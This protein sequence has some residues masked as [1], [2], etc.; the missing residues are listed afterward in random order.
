M[1]TVPRGYTSRRVLV[2]VVLIC[3]I[4]LAVLPIGSRGTAIVRASLDGQGLGATPTGRS[5]T[6]ADQSAHN[7][8]TST[9]LMQHGSVEPLS[10]IPPLKAGLVT[11]S[12]AISAV[13][14]PV[15][16]G[17]F[18]YAGCDKLYG[19][20]WDKNLPNSP[21]NIDILDGNSVL[22]TVTA[23]DYRSDLPGNKNHAF[24]YIP[25]ASLKDGRTHTINVRFSGT[26]T[27]LTNSPKSLTCAPPVPTIS[28]YSWSSTPTANQPFNGTITGSGFVFG[29][30]VFFCVN[31]SSTCYEH[32]SAGISVN[33]T[34]SLGVSN[35]NL[36]TG[37]Y[38][39]Y[40]QT[41]GGQSGRS[42]AFNVQSTPTPPT[43][44]NYSWNSTPTANQP[45]GGTITGTGFASGIRVFFCVNGTSTCYEHPSAGIAV[46]G[47]T[48]L[49][50]SNVNLGGGSYQIYVQTSAGQS[51]R[52]TAFTVQAALPTIT[53]YSWNSTPTANQ[54][55]GGTITGTGF[56]SGI[57]V[58]FC[59]NGTGT[60]Y[61][62][63]SA[64]ITVNNSTSLSLSNINLGSGSYQIYV[65]TSAG[66]SAR[67]TAF[68]VQS[69]TPTI[70]G[71]SW[72]ST[73]TPNEPFGGTISGTG[74][75][76][77]ARV[78]FCVNGTATCYE[79]P[80]AGITVNSSTVMS[81]INVNLGSGSYQIYVQTSAGQ[82]ARSTAFTVQSPLPT[83]TTYSWASTPTANQVFGGTITGTGFI[84]GIRVF[85]CVSST[86]TCY[87]HPSVGVI[88]NGSTSLS[89]SNVNLGSGSWQV[90]VQTSAGQSAR[91]TAFTVQAGAQPVITGISPS[92]L[93]SKPTDQNVTVFGNN[94]QQNL[95]VGV[96]FPN[97][98]GATLSGTQIQSVTPNSF[99]MRITLGA[100]GTWSIRVN[101]PDGGQSGTFNFAVQSAVQP[102]GVYS[103][104]PSS[105]FV[106]SSDQDVVVSG[107][108]FQPNLTA[109][110]TFPGGGGTTLS[111][112]QIQN[113]TNSSFILRITLGA[114][115][116]WSL[117]VNN[118]DGGQS[119][120]FNFSVASGG[121]N[122]TIS[123]INPGS[124]VAGGADQNVIISGTNFQPGL[125]VDLGFPN[126]GL[127]TLQGTGQ[128]Q[129]VTANSF[130]MRV[131]LNGAGNWTMRVLNPDGTQSGQFSFSVLS[132]GPPPSGLPTS[133]L[134]PVIGTL[135][136]T[137]SNQGIGDGNWEF[138]Q[139][140][141]GFHTPTGGISSSNDTFAWDANLYTPTSRNADAGKA[142]YAVADG[143]VVSYVGTPP[144][145]GPGA[146]LIAHPNSQNPVWFSGYLHMTNV[147]V[148]MNQQVTT[149]TVIGDVGRIG[150]D[151]DHLHFVV[152]SGQNTRGNLQSFNVTLLERTASTINAPI[153]SSI[154]PSVVDQS[155]TPQLITINGANF[156]SGSI[157]EAQAPNG[158]FFNVTPETAPGVSGDAPTE[159]DVEAKITAVTSNSITA[160]VLFASGGT[161]AFSVINRPT[162]SSPDAPAA[163]NVDSAD[164]SFAVSNSNTVRALQ[165]GR[166]PV[167]LIPGIM[168]SK[169][170]KWEGGSLRNLWPGAANP[171]QRLND[172][173]ELKNNVEKPDDYRDI[174]DRPV[175]AT[176]IIR[177]ISV[178]GVPLKDFYGKLFSYLIGVGYSPYEVT[179]PSQ[180]TIK[181]CDKN[182]VGADL[183][184]FSY[185]W[186]NSN[187]TSARDLY[188]YV[189]CIKSIRGNPADFKVHIIA[190]SMGGLVARRYILNNPGTHHV[191]RMVSLGTP[192]LGAPKFLNTLEFGEKFWDSQ[193]LAI[194]PTTVK[195]IAPYIKGAH[196]LI[197]SKAYVDDLVTLKPFFP[198]GEDGWNDF[199]FDPAKSTKYSFSRL[200]AAMNTRYTNRP[201]DTTNIFHS[202]PGQDN[203]SGDTSGVTYF[204]FV[205]YGQSTTVSI[206]AK[207]DWLSG[208]YFDLVRTS[209]G[210]GTVP[211]V[212]AL[213]NGRR[214]YRGPI[215]LEKG[216][217]LN[218]GGLVSD[219]LTFGFINCVVN[220]P[221]AAACINNGGFAPGASDGLAAGIEESE[222]FVGEPNYE[223]KVIGSQ[224]VTINDSF[225]NTTNPFSTSSD[226]GVRTV[227]TDVTGDSYLSA[228]FPLDQNY[229]VVLRAP[230]R[231]VSILLTKSDGQTIN[232][233]IR[234]LDITLPSGVWALL[235]ITP[236]GVA[237]LKYDSDG[238][239]TFDTSVSPTVSVTGTPA[240]DVESP[241][242]TINETVLNGTS[243]ITLE[244]ADA[245][246]G[247][248]Q[249]MYSVD[250][251]TY[252]PYSTPLNLNPSQVPT[253][254]A[255]ADD[256]VANRSG[257]VTYK[258]AVPLNILQF[259]A[260]SYSA[261]EGNGRATI[262]VT[263]AGDSSVAASVD[264]QTVDDPAAVPC[265]PALKK[266]DGS[267][268]P[269]GAAYARCDYATSIETVTFAAGD[270]QPKTISIPLIDDAYIEGA[271]TLQLKLL[272][273]TGATLSEQS[274]ITLTIVDNDS[275]DAQN[276]IL[277]TPFFVRMQYLDFLS[278]EPEIGEPWSGVL[279]RCAN[280]FNL[281]P[282]HPT[283]TCDR[284]IVSQSF[285][286]S[287]E[288]RLKGFYAFT[289]YRV[290]FNRR[291]AYEEIIPDM[292]SVSGATPE[293]VYQKRVALPVNFTSR[294]EFKGLYD[295]L[296]NTAFVNTLFDRYGL[297]SITTPDP[298]NPEGGTR[299]VLTRADLTNR[300]GASGAGSLTRAQV[301]R[302]VVES[303]EVGVAEYN[304]AFVAMQYYGYLRRT[305]EEDGYQA[306]LRVINQDPN[307]IRI[308]VNGFMNSTEYRLRFGQP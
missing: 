305:P 58:F 268:Y 6:L 72:N 284:L 237:A 22:Q 280:P 81:L 196:E 94:F 144:S 244:G 229:R 30:R 68:T 191:D 219:G 103:L 253:V 238:N 289:L 143:Q 282:N 89:V 155:S 208:N 302:A 205:G 66:Q 110:V 93:T 223:L 74:F 173:R 17:Y 240:Q 121:Q 63:P 33:S 184:V 135:R 201:G 175:V 179:L 195:E 67:S 287:P 276:P 183:F 36:G 99:V 45:F 131:T 233:A 301:L 90:Y 104:N 10:L 20:A 142:V 265:N 159:L 158:Q 281:D 71:Y 83:I 221:D 239:G 230:A 70:T 303:N 140:K 152:Y 212:S 79:Q 29:T 19:W 206:I 174:S 285:F 216:F 264:F 236:Q 106:N 62:H 185:D 170:S 203:W 2:T 193:S 42:A 57:R 154:E 165:S 44:S 164:S 272:N 134:S 254:Y 7:H 35:V 21:I 105:L 275:V 4:S 213:R 291:P 137:T 34:T 149:A 288:F 125:R 87:E 14:A 269:Q 124:P 199:D 171:I 1:S 245:G 28:G 112:A 290:A 141:S 75:A 222:A 207:K 197:P 250:G 300:L 24:N 172:H 293:E 215:K 78:F 255:F 294:P 248:K 180:R 295:A 210:D 130:L 267:S 151:N 202:Q 80:S 167:I 296:S 211:L 181:G 228:I 270:T 232:Q 194:L 101:S 102:P 18:D 15:Y 95:T 123:S 249:I 252:L 153:I 119:P 26:S 138:N 161:Y 133:V 5:V 176:D 156:Q 109:T 113:V 60:C 286:G 257:V 163:Q 114:T 231:P 147:R 308:M 278:R 260:A 122:P 251:I 23:G 13:L 256:N 304:Q 263:R 128:I 297:G 273:P 292:R 209:D 214:D 43:I 274:T 54:S 38:Q 8:D 16:E 50:V 107:S 27:Y 52:S 98:G 168:G 145:G 64:G 243:R 12:Q 187:W 169:I 227:Q 186:R 69:I 299:V 41:S 127:G 84:S 177:N 182:Q 266:P 217:P 40:V 77:G 91:S 59:V 97:G 218:H 192:W 53:N 160:R 32:P 220:V 178:E 258:L 198:F 100:S 157:I 283:A 37:S 226:E 246:T 85:F 118:P 277:T 116:A 82:S 139:Y 190:H 73:P 115:G 51:A 96:T 188:E 132:S 150:A 235:E 92:S 39:I 166:T 129:N 48:S 126:G 225:G 76:S 65:Q 136:V 306:W 262:V 200:M 241:V 271:E 261:N 189:Q 49:S 162:T 279:N 148:T 108:N 111:G 25:P 117:R 307:N 120:I 146:V 88:L 11:G 61:E 242:V 55:F 31:G 47:S 46:N 3:L 234:Y 259:G 86:A 247:V 204:N 224:S 9:P 298:T 56:A